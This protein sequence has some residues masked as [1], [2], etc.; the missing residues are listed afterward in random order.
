MRFV[1]CVFCFC[2]LAIQ[3][4]A[5]L[6][7]TDKKYILRLFLTWNLNLTRK[8][9]HPFLVFKDQKLFDD[10]FLCHR[11]FFCRKKKLFIRDEFVDPSIFSSEII[12]FDHPSFCR[13]V[14]WRRGRSGRLNFIAIKWCSRLSVSLYLYKLS[15]FSL[16]NL[17][18]SYTTF[19]FFGLPLFI[20]YF[21]T[22]LSD[23]QTL[24]SVSFSLFSFFKFI[25]F[26]SS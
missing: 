7:T 23:S 26:L 5:C 10:W 21:V 2:L 20:F 22:F 4:K 17:C 8:D 16:P 1:F 14:G 9:G 19:H 12:G 6:V 25:F 11:N 24:L 18:N 3:I 13:G 15:N